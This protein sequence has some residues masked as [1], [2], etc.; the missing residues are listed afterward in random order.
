MKARI[1]RHIL[2]IALA[3]IDFSCAHQKIA[4]QSNNLPQSDGVVR[5]NLLPPYF[6]PDEVELEK[7][8]AIKTQIKIK[9][10]RR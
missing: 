7:K 9:G 5:P 3:F 6:A 1:I 4:M 2:I 10:E 8:T